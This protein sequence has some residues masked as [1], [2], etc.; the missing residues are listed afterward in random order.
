M[1]NR[2]LIL[3]ALA[4]SPSIIYNPLVSRDTDLMKEALKAM[5]VGI[6]DWGPHLRVTP[7]QLHGATVDCALAGTIMPV[8]YTHL[9]LPTKRIV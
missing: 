9:T 7:G 3:A 8:S 2:A 4:D 1:T 6:S 5:G